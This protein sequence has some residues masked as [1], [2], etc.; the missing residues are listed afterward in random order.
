MELIFLIWERGGVM[1]EHAFVDMSRI[2][3]LDC[4]VYTVLLCA[5]VYL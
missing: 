1:Y 4:Y 3:V 2:E 5:T